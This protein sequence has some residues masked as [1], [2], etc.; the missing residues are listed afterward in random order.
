MTEIIWKKTNIDQYYVIRGW[1]LKRTPN[2]SRLFS[3]LWVVM[4]LKRFEVDLE[5]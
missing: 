5:K 4:Y 2:I 3:L 1:S